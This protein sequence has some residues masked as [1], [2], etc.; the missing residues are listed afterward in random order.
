MNIKQ[1][2]FKHKFDSCLN[3]EREKKKMLLLANFSMIKLSKFKCQ[4][5]SSNTSAEHVWLL[6]YKHTT[7][8]V[9]L[10]RQDQITNIHRPRRVV[11]SI[12]T[13]QVYRN[14]RNK[15]KEQNFRKFNNQKKSAVIY[16]VLAIFTILGQGS[17][18]NPL[19]SM[20]ILKKENIPE[21]KN[22]TTLTR[23]KKR[24]RCRENLGL[25]D[26]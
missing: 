22:N 1:V 8:M 18:V 12:R 11:I 20:T 15:C 5:M 19:R 10:Q 26:Q 14:C 7:S 17:N 21:E 4:Y 13:S 2:K 16:M 6:N 24:M 3:K 23:K 9:Q 25:I